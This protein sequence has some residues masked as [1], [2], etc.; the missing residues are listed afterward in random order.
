MRSLTL[1][2]AE[3]ETRQTLGITGFERYDIEGLDDELT[4]RARLT[5]R[6][7]EPDGA[8]RQFTVHSRMDIDLLTEPLGIGTDGPVFLR[9]IWPSP[10]EV[11]DTILT[12]VKSDMFRA[13]YA[14]VFEGDERWRELD[15]PEG[16]TFAW[17]DESPYVK[18][19]PFFDGMTRE[20]P[21]VQ[22][23][24]GARVLAMLGDSITTDHISPAG[25]IPASS[26]A[27]K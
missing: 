26:P 18:N 19:P 7:T 27:G 15:V 3:G 17:S 16:E 11:E 2:Y 24:A 8:V 25:S 4:P 10:K 12:A 9:D 23:V 6:A 5:V 21:G 20:A 22:P 13:Q 1:E 14:N